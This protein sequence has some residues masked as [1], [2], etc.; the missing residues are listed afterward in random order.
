MIFFYYYFSETELKTYIFRFLVTFISSFVPTG[1][2][3]ISCRSLVFSCSGPTWRWGEAHCLS[4]TRGR[5][6]MCD[7]DDLVSV[8]SPITLT[9]RAVRSMWHFQH[10]GFVFVRMPCVTRQFLTIKSLQH[11]C[12]SLVLFLACLGKCTGSSENTEPC[13]KSHDSPFLNFT[14]FLLGPS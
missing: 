1:C 5:H 9:Q 12:T 4:T 7:R 13:Q 11:N 8:I 10:P 14:P 6:P 3:L 2:F